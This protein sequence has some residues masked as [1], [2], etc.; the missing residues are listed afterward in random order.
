MLIVFKVP[1]DSASTHLASSYSRKELTSETKATH[2]IHTDLDIALM[3]EE[4]DFQV[5]L[6]R[7]GLDSSY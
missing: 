7:T 1:Q 3:L 2:S 6:N 4:N 5:D